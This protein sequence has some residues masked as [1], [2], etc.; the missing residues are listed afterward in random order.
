MLQK[1]D[2]FKHFKGTSLDDKNI[3]EV[4]EVGVKY[5]GDKSDTPIENLVIYK[6][7]FQNKIFARELDDLTAELSPEKQELYGQK[8]RA[9]KLTDDEIEYIK[10]KME[11]MQNER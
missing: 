1:G 7:I 2:L 5:S 9:E 8:H 4:L 3:C 6:N 10:K 11:N